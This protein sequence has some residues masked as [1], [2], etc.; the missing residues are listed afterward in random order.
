MSLF[1]AMCLG[2]IAWH[3]CSIMLGMDDKCSEGWLISGIRNSYWLLPLKHST[4]FVSKQKFD[5]HTKC[6]SQMQ[7]NLSSEQY[8]PTPGQGSFFWKP[9]EHQILPISV[10]RIKMHKRVTEST[11]Q[12]S[13][14]REEVWGQRQRRLAC[15]LSCLPLPGWPA[16]A[17]IDCHHAP[18]VS[19]RKKEL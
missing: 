15:W 8:R 5:S 14:E 11:P 6:H 4:S 9:G 2:F 16:S 17:A 3:T 10:S 1:T 7:R 18:L 12:L 13:Q 19:D